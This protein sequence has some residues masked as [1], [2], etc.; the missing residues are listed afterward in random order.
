MSRYCSQTTCDAQG[1]ATDLDRCPSCGHETTPP[2]LPPPPAAHD[3]SA[4]FGL[5]QARPVLAEPSIAKLDDAVVYTTKP[6]GSQARRQDIQRA[7]SF[8]LPL[9][10]A[11]ICITYVIKGRLAILFALGAVLA[12]QQFVVVARAKKLVSPIKEVLELQAR[13]SP[14]LK[15]LCVEAKCPLPQVTLRRTS[16]PAGVL[17]GRNR[18]VL[19]L[20]PDF[21]RESDDDVLRAVIAHEVA[22]LSSSDVVIARRRG[23]SLIVGIYLLWFAYFYTVG[24]E[25]WT[26]VFILLVFIVPLLRI[27][28]LPLG[29]TNRWRETR[30]DLAGVSLTE[31]PDAMIRGLE[32]VYGIAEENRKKIY[33]RAPLK[34]ALIPFSIRATTHP[35]LAV[36]I[37]Q[38]RAFTPT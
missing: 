33:G 28:A 26:S 2:N 30:A 24:K 8:M 20:S 11:A 29:F 21:V 22:H 14:A 38:L 12:L 1:E 31:N 13:I 17:P 5:M 34:W 19:L 4:E 10:E 16:I 9:G 37:E 23:Q 27:V 15:E 32:L 7:L 3:N 36:R 25:S 6:L 35:P 18:T